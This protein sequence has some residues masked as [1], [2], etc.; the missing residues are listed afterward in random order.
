M[1]NKNPKILTKKELVKLASKAILWLVLHDVTLDK[2]CNHG[3]S[4]FYLNLVCSLCPLNENIRC[5]E[6]LLLWINDKKK[7]FQLPRKKFNPRI[8]DPSL[9]CIEWVR[10]V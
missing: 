8:S 3:D 5:K 6:D 10:H 7:V 2:Y 4:G 1:N 9:T